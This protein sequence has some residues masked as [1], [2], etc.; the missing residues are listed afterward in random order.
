MKNKEQCYSV[1]NEGYKSWE[2]MMDDLR[3][4]YDEG[5]EV[6]VWE[7]DKKEYKHSDFIDVNVIIN[8]MQC[9]AYDEAGEVAEEYLNG[10]SDKKKDELKNHIADWFV[11]N[12]KINFYGVENE[13]KIMVIVD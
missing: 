8:D 2:G 11:Q 12:G 7:A 9:N 13:K 6:L 3:E 5:E 1:D 10:L 4:S